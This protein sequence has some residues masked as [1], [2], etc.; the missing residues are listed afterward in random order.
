MTLPCK[1]HPWTPRSILIILKLWFFPKIWLINFIYF[2]ISFMLGMYFTYSHLY[3]ERRDVLRVSPIKKKKMWSTALWCDIRKKKLV[4]SAVV[5]TTQRAFW[6]KKTSIWQKSMTWNNRL[7]PQTLRH[8]KAVCDSHT[9]YFQTIYSEQC[10]SPQ[11]W[12]L[13]KLNLYCVKPDYFPVRIM[14]NWRLTAVDSI[15]L[16]NQSC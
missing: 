1:C 15:T 16:R 5:S 8:I 6:W 10:V 11:L 4:D 2:A 7:H 13:H 12:I 14:R 9:L 3:S